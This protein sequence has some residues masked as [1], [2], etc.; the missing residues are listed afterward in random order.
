MRYADRY[1]NSFKIGHTPGLLFFKHG[2]ASLLL[3]KK[4]VKAWRDLLFLKIAGYVDKIKEK[5]QIGELK[6]KHLKF[7][8]FF[9]TSRRN[10][11]IF[12]SYSKLYENLHHYV[13]STQ[14]LMDYAGSEKIIF[15][16][17]SQNL[18]NEFSMAPPIPDSLGDQ[19]FTSQADFSPIDPVKYYEF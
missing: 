2:D 5:T 19:I 9:G 11:K 16:N 3:H 1:D 8:I 10:L 4:T 7:V 12:Q 15:Y 14:E 13:G 6:Q 18:K 17:E